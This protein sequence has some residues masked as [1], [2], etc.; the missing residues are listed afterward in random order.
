MRNSLIFKL[1]GAFLLVVAIGAIVI[2]WLTSRATQNAFTVYGTRNGQALAQR[3]SPILADYYSKNMSWQGVETFLQLQLSS[4]AAT[5]TTGSGAGQGQGFGQG[6]GAGTGRQGGIWGALGQRIIF[7]DRQGII[8]S[9][10]AGELN[11]QTLTSAQLVNGVPVMVNDSLA[12]TIIV[13]PDDFAGAN[14]PAGQFLTS[15]NKSIILSVVFASAIA[16]LLGAILF[17]EITAPLRLLNKAASGIASGDLS[18]RVPIRSHDELGELSQTFNKMAESLDRTE[19]QRQHL[20]ADIAHELRTPI[21][22]IQANLEA[23]LDEVLPLDAEQVAAVHNETLL[24][25]RL[26]GDLRLL[27]EAE[28]GALKLDL[29]ETEIGSLIQRVAEKIKVQAQQNGI[30]LEIEIT[31]NLPRIWI[32]ADRITQVLNNLIGNALRYTSQDGKIILSA[33]KSAG[34]DGTIQISVTDTGSGIG[35]EALPFVFDRFYRAD[36]SRARNSGGSGL[37][38]AIVKQLVEAHGGKVEAIS[39]AFSSAHQRGYGTRITITLRDSGRTLS[40]L[41]DS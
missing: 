29:Q 19:I 41:S 36:Q 35:T 40:G 20:M 7:A 17:F 6:H 9:D 16:L 27:S 4:I 22:V 15:V 28:A 30:N 11:G 21:T 12:G 37:G 34:L 14:T 18:Q 10:T 24:L 39:P 33:T 23:M 32:D 31:E 2:F 3:L 38:L 1:M 5:V 8:I 26:V 25:S 13:T